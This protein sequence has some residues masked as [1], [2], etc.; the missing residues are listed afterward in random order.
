MF[1]HLKKNHSSTFPIPR[2]FPIL[3]ISR[4][5]MTVIQVA[6]RFPNVIFCR[7]DAALSREL[8]VLKKL[9]LNFKKLLMSE[10]HTLLKQEDYL[11]F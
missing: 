11:C 2:A 6:L 10:V 8:S 7:S 5:L 3:P 9:R 4:I 1:A